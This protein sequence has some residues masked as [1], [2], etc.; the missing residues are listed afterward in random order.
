M[1]R[2]ERGGERRERGRGKD[3]Y[4]LYWGIHYNKPSGDLVSTCVDK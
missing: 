2:K 3:N 1:E 4:I